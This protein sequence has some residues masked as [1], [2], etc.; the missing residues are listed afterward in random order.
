MDKQHMRA[1]LRLQ[2]VARWNM[3][4]TIRSQ[5]VMEHSAAVAFIAGRLATKLG[6]NV[7]E[8]VYWGLLHDIDEAT[9]GDIPSH[10]KRAVNRAG[11]DMNDMTDFDSV[12]LV[13][14]DLIKI[15]D[16]M[17]GCV[18]LREYRHGSH[19]EWVLCDIDNNFR[20][21][22]DKMSEEWQRAVHEVW[23]EV[24]QDIKPDF[25]LRVNEGARMAIVK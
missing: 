20:E 17:E 3:V 9:T 12:P 24:T 15:A 18:F 16:K 7:K 13:F 11:V 8:A 1:G 6:L 14:R 21:A 10:V 25:D 4:R 19:S 23:R 5:S 2:D 22:V